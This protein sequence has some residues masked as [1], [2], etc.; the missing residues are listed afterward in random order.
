MELN[1]LGATVTKEHPWLTFGVWNMAA[2]GFCVGIFGGLL[3][4]GAGV[5]MMPI[6]T[7]GFG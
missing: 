3:G 2:V 4:L 6:L 7:G 1:P 5:I